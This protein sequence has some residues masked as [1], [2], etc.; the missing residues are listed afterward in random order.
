MFPFNTPTKPSHFQIINNDKSIKNY[1]CDIK[2]F[3][4]LKRIVL[5]H[6]PD[7]FFHLAAQALVKKSYT[8]PLLTWNSNLLGTV[9]CFRVS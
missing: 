2:N 3:N 9:K 7:F 5:K 4:E 1:I 8:D 6:K